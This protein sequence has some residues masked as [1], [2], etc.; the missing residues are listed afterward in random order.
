MNSKKALLK[1]KM[2]IDKMK[3]KFIYLIKNTGLLFISNFASKILVFLLVPFYTSVLTTTEY[4]TYDLIYTTVQLLTPILTL[5]IVDS[6]IRFSIDS[7]RENKKNVFTVGFKYFLISTILILLLSIVFKFNNALKLFS[8]HRVQ[9]IWIFIAYTVNNY[10]CQFARGIEDVTGVAISGIIGTVTMIVLNVTLLLWFKLGL[11]GY[12]YAM[13]SS[14]LFPVA[15]LIY[16]DRM[17]EYFDLKYLSVKINEYEK[18]MLHYCLPL[19]FINLSWYINNVSDRYVVSYMCGLEENGIYSVS[20][21][22]PAILNAVQVVFIQA[23][24]LSAVREYSSKDG[25]PFYRKT[26]QGMQVIMTMLCSFLILI[27]KPLSH[28]L[29]VNEFYAAWQYVPVLLIYIVF[30]TLSGVLGGIFSA[31]KDSSLL[32]WTGIVGSLVNIILNVILVYNLGTM[33]AA[34]AT[35]ISSIVIWGMRFYSSRQHMRLKLKLDRHV[36]QYISLFIQ[37]FLMIMIKETKLLVVSQ[38]IILIFMTYLNIKEIRSI[39]NDII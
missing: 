31:T 19:I 26:Y 3:D 7:N 35:V 33:G 6:V 14:L 10:I 37:A 38:L 36:I 29:F 16:R 11:V 23:W 12:F 24:Q 20:Y 5:N 2:K 17:W 1:R 9:F 30:N 34:I 21:K 18:E 13:T 25:E 22:I 27:T 15:F 4:G 32:A 39:K 28:C 8:S